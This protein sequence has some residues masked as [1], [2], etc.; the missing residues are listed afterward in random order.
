MQCLLLYFWVGYGRENEMEDSF[1]AQH[2]ILAGGA[3]FARVQ[4]YKSRDDLNKIFFTQVKSHV[5]SSNIS[6]IKCI[7]QKNYKGA[8]SLYL[9]DTRK[10]L[11][12]GTPRLFTD[13]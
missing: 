1:S 13:V 8:Q 3:R 10:P 12:G 6:I 5:P 2:K 9:G 11:R 7:S 4:I